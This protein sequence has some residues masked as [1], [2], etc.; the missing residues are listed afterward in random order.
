M[1]QELPLTACVSGT[2][3]IVTDGATGITFPAGDEAGYLA[4]LKRA[5][6]MLEKDYRAMPPRRG[7]RP[8]QNS[9]WAR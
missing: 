2:G 1:R 4:A 3:D 9:P 7:Q 8:R 5:L 6:S